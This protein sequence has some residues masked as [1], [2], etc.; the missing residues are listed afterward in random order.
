MCSVA[1]VFDLRRGLRISLITGGDLGNE[2][3]HSFLGVGN[4]FGVLHWCHFS[5]WNFIRLRIS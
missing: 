1:L 2:V 5:G 3:A 4:M